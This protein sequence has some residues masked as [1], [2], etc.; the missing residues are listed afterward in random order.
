MFER[1]WNS[2]FS[3]Y[4]PNFKPYKQEDSF[5]SCLCIYV[6]VTAWLGIQRSHRTG[7]LLL[8]C[9]AF[10]RV[11]YQEALCRWSRECY[12]GSRQGSIP[13][14]KHLGYP[15]A[16]TGEHIRH[17]YNSKKHFLMWREAILQ[18]FTLPRDLNRN[19]PLLTEP[20]WKTHNW[21]SKQWSNLQPACKKCNRYTLSKIC[22]GLYHAASSGSVLYLEQQDYG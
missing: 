7:D 19:I 16:V 8:I 14:P 15:T 13:L 20:M 17:T 10:L 5:F 21:T 9:T 3:K 2:L 1:H 6:S 12:P 4:K 18:G 22:V 11:P